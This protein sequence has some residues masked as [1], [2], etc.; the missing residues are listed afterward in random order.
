MKG[1][2]GNFICWAKYNN[3]GTSFKHRATRFVHLSV[4]TCTCNNE[5]GWKDGDI[6]AD[7]GGE[8]KNEVQKC[9]KILD[10]GG[11]PLNFG[12]TRDKLKFDTFLALYPFPLN[13]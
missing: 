6:R 8:V 1:T 2:T 12:V 5:G 13:K 3:P 7:Q 11:G 10:T 4:H 9:N